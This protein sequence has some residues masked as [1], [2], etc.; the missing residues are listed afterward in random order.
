MELVKE[1]TISVITT[2]GKKIEKGDTVVFNLEDGVTP[3]Y[4]WELV[5]RAH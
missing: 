3:A 2:D 4:S 5:R 1:T